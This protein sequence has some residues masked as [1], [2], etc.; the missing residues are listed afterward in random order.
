MSLAYSAV[1]LG[2]AIVLMTSCRRTT[3]PLEK[4]VGQ[5][6]TTAARRTTAAEPRRLVNDDAAMILTRV[7]CLRASNCSQ[8]GAR[9]R[10]HEDMCERNLFPEVAAVVRPEACPTGVDEAKLRR[11]TADLSAQACERIRLGVEDVPS[12]MRSELC[13]RPAP[14]VP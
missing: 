13:A 8:L 9:A 5:T 4:P 12:C 2:G 7:S 14:T 1:M 6:S 10:L 11:C 3:I